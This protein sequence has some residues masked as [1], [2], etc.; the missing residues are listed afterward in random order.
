MGLIFVELGPTFTP[1]AMEIGGA[2]ISVFAAIALGEILKSVSCWRSA[3]ELLASIDDELLE[4]HEE[5]ESDRGNPVPIPVWNACV[6][7]G[8]LL[9]LKYKE[10]TKLTKIY[11]EIEFFNMHRTNDFR[12]SSNKVIETYFSADDEPELMQTL[13]EWLE[14]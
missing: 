7:D 9:D 3:S 8:R 4:V 6:A 14:S 10:R 2:I 1:M 12:E 13:R 5:L 11:R